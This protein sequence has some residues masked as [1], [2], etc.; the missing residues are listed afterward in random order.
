MST[1]TTPT[2]PPSADERRAAVIRAMAQAPGLVRFAARYTS[3]I[4]DA[5]DAYQRAME[6]ALRQAPVTGD[7]DFI[8]WLHSVIKNEARSIVRDRRS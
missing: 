5:E 8:A 3:S 4:H 1:D 6:I 2:A 7:R